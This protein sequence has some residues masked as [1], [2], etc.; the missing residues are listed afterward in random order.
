MASTLIDSRIGY[1]SAAG[2]VPA[3]HRG[4]PRPVLACLGVVVLLTIGSFVHIEIGMGHHRYH[5]LVA[6]LLGDL[7]A[8]YDLNC[9]T[10]RFKSYGSEAFFQA[11]G[12][13][14]NYP[15]PVA[16]VMRAI[17]LTPIW[18]SWTYLWI[19]GTWMAVAG[20]M[21]VW[22]CVRRGVRAIYAVAFTAFLLIFSHP[23]LM[24]L[25]LCNME[26]VV[27]IVLGC[28]M[29]AFCTRRSWLAALCFGMA[30]SFKYFPLALLGMFRDVRK[31]AAG[32]VTFVA[33]LLISSW[34]L[35]PSFAVAWHGLKVQT[36]MFTAR[37][38]FKWH[39]SEG[40][41]DHSL[42]ALVKV[43]LRSM[44][45]LDL[46][47]KALPIYL[48]IFGIA[49]VAL[50]LLVIRNLPPLNQL[51]VLSAASV[52]LPPLSHD[53]TLINM[54]APLAALTLYAIEHRTKEGPALYGMFACFGVLFAPMTFVEIYD[55]RYFGQVRCLALIALLALA[56]KCRLPASSPEGKTAYLHLRSRSSSHVS[57]LQRTSVAAWFA[58]TQT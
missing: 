34:A 19:M 22:A 35:G 56:M 38:L 4:F 1:T 55:V 32:G 44:N 10:E 12:Q 50:Y 51:I 33:T 37:Y 8:G 17:F 39:A 11:S 42:F 14:F 36:G 49:F 5:D 31:I 18:P 48:A 45:R 29:W 57:I 47:P 6:A 3:K 58:T 30:G 15:A 9:Y 43:V 53:Y 28:G 2:R 41:N 24:L 52:A 25:Y 46:L 20:S 40:A 16:L 54:Y 23:V 7:T 21:F 27:W 13:P 26:L